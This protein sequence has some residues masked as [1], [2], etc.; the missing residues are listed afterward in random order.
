MKRNRNLVLR[1]RG[2]SKEDIKIG[3]KKDKR[4]KEKKRK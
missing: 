4:K 3:N 1:K 2:I